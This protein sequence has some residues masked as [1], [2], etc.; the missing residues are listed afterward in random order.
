MSSKTRLLSALTSLRCASRAVNSEPAA[1]ETRAVPRRIQPLNL[2]RSRM[3][4]AALR[5]IFTEILLLLTDLRLKGMSWPG[6]TRHA[7]SIV[8]WVLLAPGG[9]LPTL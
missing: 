7:V 2:E 8:G 9:L 1:K 6:E 4:R 5:V 3:D